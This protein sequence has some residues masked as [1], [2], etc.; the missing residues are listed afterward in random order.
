M[1]A[2][3]QGS[4]LS[5]TR[6]D[7]FV[8]SPVRGRSRAKS[9]ELVPGGQAGNSMGMTSP[10]PIL[11]ELGFCAWL[12]AA[13]PGDAIE[14]HQGFLALD[15]TAYGQPLSAEDRRGLIRTGNRAMQLAEQ[16]FVHLVQR[17]LAPGTFS[18][19]AIARPRPSRA[20]LSLAILTAEEAA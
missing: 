4:A 6:N 14:Y 10:S 5:E 1:T 15:R 3:T 18:Y 17:R 19:L 9:F 7:N 13:A 12:G 2:G 8:F 20:P 11:T 16:D